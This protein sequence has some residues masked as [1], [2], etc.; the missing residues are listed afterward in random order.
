MSTEAPDGTEH[1]P[2]VEVTSFKTVPG[3]LR[4]SAFLRYL[5]GEQEYHLGPN[6]LSL[7]KENNFPLTFY[8]SYFTGPE[9]TVS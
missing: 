9:R 5:A 2:F 1:V 7:L 4:E 8:I 6:A 3:L